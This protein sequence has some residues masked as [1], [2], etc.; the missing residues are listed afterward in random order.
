[1][2]HDR[3]AILA[4]LLLTLLASSQVRA[5]DEIVGPLR[6]SIAAAPLIVEGYA[7]RPYTS[8]DGADR[9]TIRTY[10]PLKVTRVLKGNLDASRIVLRQPGGEIGGTSAPTSDAEFTEGEE[11]IVFVGSRDPG[12]ES[13]DVSSGS[14]GKFVVRHDASGRA[15]LDVRLGADA[16]AY[17]SREKAPG[18][19]LAQVPVQL[20][21]QLAM[22]G[23]FESVAEFESV[24]RTPSRSSSAPPSNNVS[25]PVAAGS[26]DGRLP[27]G[28]R[29]L[30]IATA[31]LA[32]LGIA[33]LA[34]R[35]PD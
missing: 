32:L 4:A 24:Q 21:E 18:A 25:Q 9:A 14:R 12:D 10:T 7:Q 3:L 35:R 6:E 13:Y 5:D 2:L 27:M 15:V 11:V 28:G 26:R 31:V 1:V 33:W 22:G 20:F 30:L 34:R 8:W 17:T 19:L 23:Q 16:S 29:V